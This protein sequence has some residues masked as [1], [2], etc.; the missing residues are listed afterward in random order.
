MRKMANEYR[1]G[2]QAPA[3]LASGETVSVGTVLKAEMDMTYI[4]STVLADGKKI[5]FD[6]REL[7][8][9]EDVFVGVSRSRL[10]RLSALANRVAMRFAAM[11][12]FNKRVAAI[13]NELIH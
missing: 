4:V 12:D 7:P 3:V 11:D 6:T 10:A 2:P 9:L 5:A 13:G 1:A 8:E